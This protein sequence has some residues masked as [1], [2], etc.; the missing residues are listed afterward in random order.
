M[1]YLSHHFHGK[2]RRGEEPPWGFEKTQ[3]GGGLLTTNKLMF[4]GL[5]GPPAQPIRNNTTNHFD[6]QNWRH[7]SSYSETFFTPQPFSR[8]V[9]DK[10]SPHRNHRPH[11]SHIIW[12][13]AP[14]KSY[15]IWKPKVLDDTNNIQSKPYSAPSLL[16]QYNENNW[17]TTSQ[18]TYQNYFDTKRLQPFQ[19]H[20]NKPHSQLDE[21]GDRIELKSRSCIETASTPQHLRTM[22]KST[23]VG[24]PGRP[25][26]NSRP[27]DY[28]WRNIKY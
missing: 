11:P 18:T 10:I 4:Q 19:Q 6:P 28:S 20:R 12:P 7:R 25:S 5:A 24:E 21:R 16:R 8:H 3:K 9:I 14:N 13:L 15:M 22:Y 2:E 27:P 17:K 23:Y 26:T 1:P